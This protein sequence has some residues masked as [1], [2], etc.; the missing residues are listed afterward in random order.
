MCSACYLLTRPVKSLASR[1]IPSPHQHL[2]AVAPPHALLPCLHYLDSGSSCSRVSMCNTAVFISCWWRVSMS[3]HTHTHTHTHKLGN[4]G[5]LH[6]QLH[7]IAKA[8]QKCG[9]CSTLCQ[10]PKVAEAHCAP[11]HKLPMLCMAAIPQTTYS[12]HGPPYH[13]SHIRRARSPYHKLALRWMGDHTI[14]CSRWSCPSLAIGM[15]RCAAQVAAVQRSAEAWRAAAA[16]D[17]ESVRVALDGA[18]AAQSAAERRAAALE[19]ALAQQ[20]QQASLSWSVH[21]QGGWQGG[22]AR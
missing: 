9:V 12:L 13:K 5:V 16:A 1:T 18:L 2:N 14:H 19:A 22:L 7:S 8:I 17:L 4:Q 11:Y 15:P 20:E 3:A 6:T 10:A 21:S